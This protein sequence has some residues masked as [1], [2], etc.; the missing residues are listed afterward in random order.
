M[1]FWSGETLTQRAQSALLISDFDPNRVDCNAYGLRLGKEAF[2]SQERAEIEASTRKGQIAGAICVGDG[3]RIAVPPGQ[4]AYLLTEE[5]VTIPND[6]MGF[7]SVKAGKKL[8]GLINV[9]GFHVDPGWSGHLI[10]GVFNAGPKP[11]LLE[12]KE[13]VFLL[14]FASLD[15]ETEKLY[16]MAAGDRYKKIPGKLLEGMNAPVPSLYILQDDLL[17]LREV[18]ERAGHKASLA[19]TAAFG[20]LFAMAG[21]AAAVIATK[22]TTTLTLDDGLNAPARAHAEV[23]SAA[24]RDSLRISSSPSASEIKREGNPDLHTVPTKDGRKDK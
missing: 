11:L 4:F 18:S 2:I 14:W 10:F 12:R 15:R 1:T 19:M 23:D 5:Q 13:I 8:Q 17:K 21:I 22:V 3:D 24:P 20:A 16:P 6:A 9:S 7:I